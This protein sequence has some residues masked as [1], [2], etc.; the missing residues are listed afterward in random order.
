MQQLKREERIAI[1]RIIID[2]IE[3]DFVIEAGEME[4]FERAISKEWFNITDKMLVEAKKIDL[5]KALEM[6]KELDIERR[7][8]LV[9]MLKQLSLSDEVCVP[10]EATL[11]YAIEQV[12]LGNANLYSILKPDIEI[13][14]LT[15]IY[16][17]N[18]AS[19]VGERLSA[20]LRTIGDE[21]SSA[22]L[23]LV[24]IPT[25]VD[26]FRA[27]D[28]EYLRKSIKYKIPSSSEERV[29]EI[30][31]K[32]CGLTTA[33]FCRDLLYKRLKLNLID[34][35]PSL[36][37]KINDSDIIDKDDSEE[38]YRL[39]FS[40]F[41]QLELGEDVESDIRTMV[42]TFRSMVSS[43]PC[44]LHPR[45]E[46]KFI[47]EGFHRSLF[48]L[49]AYGR[50]SHECRLVFDFRVPRNVVY[51]ESMEGETE[52]IPLKLNPQETTLYYMM[53]KHSLEGKGLDWRENIPAEEKAEIL[54]EYNEVYYRVGHANRAF[55]YKDRTQVHHIKNR[56]RLLG[57]IANID[58][59]IPEHT[60][61]GSDSAYG[62]RCG[63]RY[64]AFRF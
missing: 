30:C 12:L 51:F 35:R 44:E 18:E 19:A 32:L 64:V 48:D 20:N 28:A 56:L 58:M 60:R 47:Y 62:V 21:M 27:M 24:Y 1:A 55:E 6:L 25:I 26:D 11:I 9:R 34:C 2:L 3:A 46:A 36:L 42:A 33:Q 54:R 38:N 40:N 7:A 43:R 23:D 8:A 50:E 49:I 31:E 15:A 63:G 41:L 53:V 5:A 14:N 59:F 22:G 4:F 16:V 52:R 13:A 10:S 45:R 61:S 37:L 29:A 17:E 39:R 57:G